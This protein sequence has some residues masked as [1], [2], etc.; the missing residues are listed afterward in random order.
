V[1]IRIW[2]DNFKAFLQILL[3]NHFQGYIINIEM[4]RKFIYFFMLLASCTVNRIIPGYY[5]NNG[6]DYKRSLKLNQD[7]TFALTTENFDNKSAC[8]GKWK[9]LSRDTLLLKCDSESFPAIITSGYISEREQKVV[10]LGNNQIKYKHMILTK[11][12]K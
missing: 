7:G 12:K 4:M 3:L 2:R 11:S 8:Q 5:Y 9:Y 1:H 6:T 10:L